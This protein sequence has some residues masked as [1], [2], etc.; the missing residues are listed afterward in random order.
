[1]TQT[2]D[3]PTQALMA[4]ALEQHRLGLLQLA[5]VCYRQVLA[6]EAHHADATHFLGVLAAQSGYAQPALE[7][8]E[9]SIGLDPNSGH[10][11]VNRGNVLR[12]LG[13]RDE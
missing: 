13:R 3:I 5:E 7:L 1:M 2:T 12:S 11:H 4:R 8:I 9:R 6:R 10:Y